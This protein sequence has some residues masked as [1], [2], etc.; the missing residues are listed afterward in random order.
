MCQETS[1]KSQEFR[2]E[3]S[4]E[5]HE[6]KN[7]GY[8]SNDQSQKCVRKC[9]HKCYYPIAHKSHCHNP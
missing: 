1:K 9:Y 4:G 8:R 5:N 7:W 6:V 2:G 3:E